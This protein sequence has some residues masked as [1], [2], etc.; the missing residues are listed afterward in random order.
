MNSFSKTAKRFNLAAWACV[1]L[2]L[3]ASIPSCLHAR[4]RAHWNYCLNYQQ[5][6]DGGKRQWALDYHKALTDIPTPAEVAA[7]HEAAARWVAAVNRWGQLGRW[8]FLPC[9]DP[10]RLLEQLQALAL[11]GH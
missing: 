1:G 10:Q 4:R 11:S 9:Y 6:I 5:Q 7:K 2:T 8:A 3:V